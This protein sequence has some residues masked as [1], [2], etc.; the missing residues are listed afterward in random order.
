MTQVAECLP[1]IQ[2]G[3]KIEEKKIKSYNEIPTNHRVKHCPRF[4]RSEL[5]EKQHSKIIGLR[6]GVII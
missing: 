5:I 1:L 3:H 2:E 4:L 6:H